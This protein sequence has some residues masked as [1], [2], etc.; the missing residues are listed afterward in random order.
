M[1]VDQLAFMIKSKVNEIKNVTVQGEIGKITVASS[2]HV[3]FDL[4]SKKARVSCVCW[5]SSNL[6]ASKGGANVSIQ[7]VDYY[8]PFGK[9]QA[10]VNNI[11]CLD[12]NSDIADKHA[13]IISTLTKDGT[14]HR[15]RLTIPEIINHLCIITSD[16]S[17]AYHDMIE[18]INSRW[19]GLKTTI[20]HS[21]VQGQQAISSLEL[22]FKKAHEIKPDVIICGRGGGS[23]C[24]LD[25]FNDER[26]VKCFI[27]TTIPIV[28]AVGHES[29]HCICD[30]VSDVRAK[31]PT[32]SIETCISTSY[33]DRKSK[34]ETIQLD[35]VF[36]VQKKL[37]DLHKN[38]IKTSENLHIVVQNALNSHVN[39]LQNM[40]KSATSIVQNNIQKMEDKVSNLSIKLDHVYKQKL[41]EF[42]HQIK[43]LRSKLNA[44][45]I[46]QNLQN[47]YCV[48]LDANDTIVKN[49]DFI[50]ENDNMCVVLDDGKI[51][52]CVK[53]VRKRKR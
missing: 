29:D 52:V 7:S 14:I 37:Q 48:L 20:I 35:C 53:N 16:G 43:M 38:C 10:I 4:M 15:P 23:E 32:A 11:E 45:S 31:T 47:G 24:D 21:S 6:K 1:N 41:N 40:E 13:H 34:L 36:Q 51:D 8:P 49:T 27:S 50:N 12:D 42:E 2:G 30:L 39:R 33:A 22:A 18:G 5:S 19:P 26:V 28:S 3:Y 46:A 44:H 9:C 25:V 17:A